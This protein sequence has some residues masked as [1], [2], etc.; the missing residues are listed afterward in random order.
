[1][2]E[3]IKEYAEMA[4]D[5]LIM[6]FKEYSFL[7]N[8][9]KQID[10]KMFLVMAKIAKE[11]SRDLVQIKE[12]VSDHPELIA[13]E[14]QKQI[15]IRLL[16]RLSDEMTFANPLIWM[17]YKHKAYQ[18][19]S[20][21]IATIEDFRRHCEPADYICGKR[22]RFLLKELDIKIDDEGSFAG[23][24]SLKD[25]YSHKSILQASLD[26]SFMQKWQEN[27]YRITNN[28]INKWSISS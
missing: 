1:M 24:A 4:V 16:A 22:Y 26:N 15:H 7:S 20:T 19:T 28:H 27:E 10:E 21:E 25:L 5:R 2:L 9:I 6:Q 8:L 3:Q 11:S 12:E 13:L 23:K 18:G 14:K 17:M